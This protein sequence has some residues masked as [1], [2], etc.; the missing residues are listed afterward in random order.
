V[1]LPIAITMKAQVQAFSEAG[2]LILERSRHEER[3]ERS[4]FSIEQTRH[5]VWRRGSR[6]ALNSTCGDLPKKKR[7]SRAPLRARARA[8][9]RAAEKGKKTSRKK[10]RLSNATADTGAPRI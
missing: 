10:R 4:E 3:S 5:D 7:H 6:G 1:L 9:R 8:E 2:V